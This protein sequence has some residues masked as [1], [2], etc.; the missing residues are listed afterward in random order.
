MPFLFHW[1]VG[2]LPPFKGVALKLTVVPSHNDNADALM[3]TEGTT[4][5]LARVSS[6]S[7][8]PVKPE[9]ITMLPAVSLDAGV[10]VAH[11]DAL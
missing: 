1:Y 11:I 7:R 2:A 3:L 10:N 6:L 5:G 8:M 9:V 4:I